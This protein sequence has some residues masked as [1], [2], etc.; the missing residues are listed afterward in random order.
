MRYAVPDARINYPVVV[1]RVPLP[2]RA[3]RLHNPPPRA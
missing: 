3:M 2:L 1:S